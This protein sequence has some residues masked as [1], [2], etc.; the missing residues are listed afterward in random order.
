MEQGDK[1]RFKYTAPGEKRAKT[2][3]GKITSFMYKSQKAVIE[4]KDG[5]ETATAT[6]P[7]SDII[8]V[9]G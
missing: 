6:V 1:V 9:I 8:R 5:R 4:Y 7:I 3:E 2:L